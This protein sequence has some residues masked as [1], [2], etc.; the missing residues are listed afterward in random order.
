MRRL[1]PKTSSPGPDLP[2]RGRCPAGVEGAGRRPH[3]KV[4]HKST[5]LD[6]SQSPL[7]AGTRSGG[8]GYLVVD[9]LPGK[10]QVPA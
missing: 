4:S 8:T 10:E 2:H 1:I 9:N 7:H 6:G 5:Q 3:T